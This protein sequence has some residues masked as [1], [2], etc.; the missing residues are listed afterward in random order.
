MKKLLLAFL[1]VFLP[2]LLLAN[3][4]S[5]LPYTI[6]QPD[7]EVINCFV[8][9]DEYFNWLHDKDGYTIIQSRDG[10]F[11][12]GEVSGDSV[13]A[14]SYKVNSVNPADVGLKKWA[15]ISLRE[16]EKNRAFYD[17][18]PLKKVLKTAP[19]GGALNNIVVYIRFSDD[20][21]FTTTRQSMDDKF[22]LNPGVSLK[23]YF[24]DVS[25]NQLIVSSTHYPVCELTTN[26]SY[27]DI[28]PRSYYQPYNETTNPIGYNGGNN[29]S[30]RTYREHTLLKNAVAWINSNSPVS[31]S[32]NIDGDAD[33]YIDNVCFIVKGGNGAWASLLWAHSW[34][35]YSYTVNIN[36]KRLY[37]YTFQP[38]T[39]LNVQTLCH[40]M[41][42]AL[43]SPDL[44]HYMGNGINPVSSWDLMESGFGHMGAYMK[45]K[46]SNQ[47]WIENIPEISASGTYTLKPLSSPTNNCYKIQS[48]FS[49]SQFFILEYRKKAGTYEINLPGSGLLVYRIDSYYSGNSSGP[50]DEVYIYRPGGTTTSNGTPSLACFSSQTT[51]TAIN[52]TT[53][54]SSFL[55]DGSAG[56]LNI[57]NITAADTT[58][59]FTINLD[60]VFNPSNFLVT[61]TGASQIELAWDRNTSQDKVLL[62]YNTS[63][64]FGSP[65]NDSIYSIGDTISGGG[66]VLLASSD[67]VFIHTGLESGETFYYKLWSVNAANKYSNGVTQTASTWCP[68]ISTFPYTQHFTQAKKPGCWVVSTNTENN[69]GWEFGTFSGL[70][71]L[72]NLLGNYAFL[73]SYGFGNGYTQ[74]AN[75]ITPY[76]DFSNLTNIVVSFN[77]FFLNKQSSHGTFSYSIDYGQSWLPIEEFTATSITNPETFSIDLTTETAGAKYVMFKWNYSGSYEKYWAIDDFAITADLDISDTLTLTEGT[78]GE[79]YSKCYNAYQSII[80]GGGRNVV[81]FYPYSSATFIAGS[82]VR[83]LPGFHAYENSQINAYIT[84]E[85]AFCTSLTGDGMMASN[86]KSTITDAQRAPII[87]ESSTFKV[88]PNPN[89]GCFTI[90]M[91]N[92]EDNSSLILYSITGRK[93]SKTLRLKN[94]ILQVNL[95]TMERGIYFIHLNDGKSSQVKKIIVR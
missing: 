89:N 64:S 62:A 59:S 24:A 87:K 93:I 35:L 55:Q 41:F 29:G 44:Y 61:N 42:H 45:W 46:Y 20:T 66:I 5:F 31:G 23:T 27:Q 78:F 40:E 79:G 3:Y 77:H 47:T 2:Y 73:N 19:H 75:L 22:N 15:K 16:Y 38:E 70:D 1:W 85:D 8:S 67:S 57:S 21:E 95:P 37:K 54:P 51:R 58:I 68:I 86:E 7:G 43:G 9:G 17:L 4:F 48:P 6:T 49:E 83:F 80:V 69:Q 36:G 11:Y 25:Y 52:D 56:G 26:Y 90:E 34:T 60:F 33:G 84:T 10:Y 53:D 76:F 94:G 32:L 30:E 82:S 63:S 92:G 91:L 88:Y 71:T 72:P 81:V 50:P 28:N 65:I 13:A 39:Q 12:Y 18:K 14:T 74:N